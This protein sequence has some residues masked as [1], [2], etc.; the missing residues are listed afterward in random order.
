MPKK[1]KAKGKSTPSRSLHDKLLEALGTIDRPGT[2]CTSGDL[3]LVMPGL[4]VQGLGAVRLPLGKTQALE[5]ITLCHQAPYGKGTETLIDTDVRR[6]WELDPD[7]FQLTNPKWQE[8]LQVITERV[9]DELGLGRRKL[10]SHLYKLLVYEEGSFFLPH[11]DGEKLDRMVATLVIGLPSVHEG[12]ELTVTHEGTEHVIG[13]AGA[14]S[15]NELSFA[16]FYAD[17][18]HEVRPLRSGYRLCLVYNLTLATSRGK[19]GVA[20]PTTTGALDVVRGLL[21]TWREAGEAQKIAVTLEH[22]YTQDGL[23]VETLKGVDRARADVL[24]AAAERTG[25]VAHLALVTFWQSGSAEGGYDGG[26]GRYRRRRY[27]YD[28]DED[29]GD[30]DDASQYEMGEVYDQSLVANHWS[31]RQGSKV[32]LGEIRLDPEEIV[33]HLPLEDWEAS[34]EEF[35]GYTGN[36]GMT[37]E[38]WYHRAAI[39]IWP[40]GNH[41]AVLCN[42]GT[43]A[44]IGGLASMVKPLKRIAKAQREAQRQECLVFAEA[45]IDSWQP[46]G[47]RYRWEDR[48]TATDRTTF[49]RLLQELDEPDLVRRFLSNVMAIDGTIQLPK[50]FP[51]F[52]KRHGWL[53]FRDALKAVMDTASTTTVTRNAALLQTL[54]LQRDKNADR[55]LLCRE[56]AQEAVAALR[57]FD[58]NAP[59]TDWQVRAIDRV[60]LLSSLVK[61]LAT[62]K[63]D[64]PLATLIDYSL[65]AHDKY[66]V[67]DTHVAAIFSLAPWLS[68]T[69]TTPPSAISHWLAVCR[70]ELAARVGHAPV[71]PTDYRRPAKLSC[72]CQDCRELSTFLADPEASVHRFR[73]RKDRRQHLHQIIN[74][75]GC[76]LT[77]ITDRSSNPQTLVC[78]KTTASYEA[79]C[80]V[81]ERDQQFLTRLEA[82]E[83][84]LDAVGGLSGA[85]VDG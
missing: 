5:L 77:H 26:Y 21:D 73:V 40:R 60:V 85:N 7:Q 44:S 28:D 74:R 71:R 63:A 65:A 25:C 8:L 67:I 24:L 61:S 41:F 2:F 58:A 53:S 57:A 50:S 1:T 11:R 69:S 12:G 42:A 23:T 27:W 76:D 17:C 82:L 31:D 47:Q 32:S 36:A 68:A 6:V 59:K 29:E 4:D 3:P 33:D 70:S 43:D 49:L 10:A 62:I 22:Q 35:E 30:D 20:A 16:A 34:R 83:Q 51:A 81:Y 72:N 9:R 13:F 52:C 55:L 38:R 80:K 66:D 78:T 84:H 14:A 54:C 46:Q 75:H 18:Q 39:V 37:L 19:Q 56:L 79:A 48:A 64:E 15:G 45:I